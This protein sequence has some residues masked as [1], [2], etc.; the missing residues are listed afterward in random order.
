MTQN[1]PA[2]AMMLMPAR[3]PGGYR[4]PANGLGNRR[5]SGRAAGRTARASTGRRVRIRCWTTR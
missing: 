3:S 1:N 4:S 5:S 2:R